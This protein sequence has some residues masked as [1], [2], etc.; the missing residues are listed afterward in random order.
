MASCTVTP[1]ETTRACSGKCSGECGKSAKSF[2]VAACAG[3]VCLFEKKGS[4]LSVQENHPVFFS[5][6][7]VVG[8]LMDSSLK[9]GIDQLILVG[10]ANDIAWVHT[11]L[12]ADIAKHIV[13]EIEYPLVPAWF[14]PDGQG[15]VSALENL[16]R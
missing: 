3:R 14:K 13:A 15:L 1:I 7:A 10:S 6:E 12:S 9:C 8:L 2:V 4:S 16:I 5:M 11:L